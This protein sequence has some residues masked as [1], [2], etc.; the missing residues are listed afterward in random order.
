[1][2]NNF[3]KSALLAASV[4]FSFAAFSATNMLT[5]SGITGAAYSTC[6]ATVSG[7]SPQCASGWFHLDGAYSA[8]IQ[9]TATAGT[10][11]IVI[12]GRMCATCPTWT[13]KTLTNVG[14]ATVPYGI[15]PPIGWISIHASAVS[16]GTVK[17]TITSNGMAG[18][19]Q[20]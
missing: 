8:A 14:P 7:G 2:K 12:L 18:V 15:F 20:W 10:N 19:S 6:P 5:A 16:G 9:A 17:G 3:I 4:L 13:I 11:T 1:M